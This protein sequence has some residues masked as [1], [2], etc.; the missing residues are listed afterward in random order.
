MPIRTNNLDVETYRN[1]LE[2]FIFRD[3]LLSSVVIDKFKIWPGTG[4]LS[5]S[6]CI[7]SVAEQI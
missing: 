1:K 5:F 2:K 4:F 7:M 6:I 3:I